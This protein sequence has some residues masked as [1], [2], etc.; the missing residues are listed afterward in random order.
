M[1]AREMCA[2]VNHA[3]EL[4]IVCILFLTSRRERVLTRISSS[5]T[6]VT[7]SFSLLSDHPEVSGHA[8][9]DCRFP[10]T[11]ARLGNREHGP[12]RCLTH[13]CAD[14]GAFSFRSTPTRY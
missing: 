11:P 1:L 14:G 7:S 2:H 5:A 4:G 12:Q 9:E 3:I 10:V 13:C 6:G 8:P